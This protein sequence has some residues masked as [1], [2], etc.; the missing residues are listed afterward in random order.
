M[1]PSIDFYSP[2]IYFGDLDATCAAYAAASDRLVIP[3]MRRDQLGIAHMFRAIGEHNAELVAPFGL[4]SL[5]A[6]APDYDEIVDAYGAPARCGK[7]HPRGP[8]AV[9]G[10]FVDRAQ[11]RRAAHGRRIR[12]G[13]FA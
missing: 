3:E 5:H 11:P 7:R 1:T 8:D 10:F 13:R 12:P 6:G 4:D 9:R 2:D